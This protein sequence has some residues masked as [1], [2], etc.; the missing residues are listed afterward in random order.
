MLKNKRIPC[1]FVEW[2]SAIEKPHRR[3]VF[4]RGARA[5]R[6]RRGSMAAVFVRKFFFFRLHLRRYTKWKYRPTFSES[7]PSKGITVGTVRIRRESPYCVVHTKALHTLGVGVRR[8]NG[9]ATF[10]PLLCHIPLSS[11][12]SQDCGINTT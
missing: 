2:P 1:M 9:G 10:A 11:L 7:L 8:S 5:C 4:L 12:G 6:P 3:L